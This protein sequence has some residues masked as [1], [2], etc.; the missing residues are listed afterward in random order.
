MINTKKE[1]AE[2]SLNKLFFFSYPDSLYISKK[3]TL[4]CLFETGQLIHYINPND[5][6]L[7]LS[8]DEETSFTDDIYQTLRN[9]NQ[10]IWV[11]I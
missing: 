8:S 10:S 9:K 1:K 11:R 7:N 5:I 2:N 4:N 6:S 3:F